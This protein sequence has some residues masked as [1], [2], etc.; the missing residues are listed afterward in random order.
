MI[1]TGIDA[2]YYTVHD[3]ETEVAFYSKLLGAPPETQWP[4]RLAEWTFADGHSF[5]L[6]RAEGKSELRSGSA[7]FAVADVAKAVEEAM[8]FG[9]KMHD[10]GAVT[11]TPA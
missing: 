5:G 4:G 6:Y 2:V 1:V 3:I 11:D 7:M 9:A 8:T 10:G